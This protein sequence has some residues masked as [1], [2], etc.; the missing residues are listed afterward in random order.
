[1]DRLKKLLYKIDQKGYKSYK[2]IQGMYQFSHF[3]L[4]IDYVQGDP[5]A[6]PSKIRLRIPLN[7]TAM[8][9]DWC[10]RSYHRIRC[11]DTIARKVG[12][13]VKKQN[14]NI[15]GSGKSGLILFDEPSQKVIERSAVMIDH[16]FV[17]ICLSVGLPANGRRIAGQDAVKLLCTYI[18]TII[19]N[20]LFT[21]NETDLYNEIKLADQQQTIRRYLK[22]HQFIAFIANEAILARESGV[23]DQSMNKDVVPFVS[24]SSLEIA[25]KVPHQVEPIKGMV[26]KKGIT[27]IVGGGYHGKSSF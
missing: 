1:M 12:Y 25:I 21:L 13:A 26:I 10:K 4:H 6:S 20:S 14:R 15:R 24:P 27:L 17:T 23:S 16:K 19:A 18:P 3:F 7:K 9:E 22:E 5:Y 11:E 8:K 2:E